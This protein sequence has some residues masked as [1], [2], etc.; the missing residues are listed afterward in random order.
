MA[1]S[2]AFIAIGLVLSILAALAAFLITYEEWSHHYTSKREPLKFA[3]E[4]SI[5]AFVVFMVLTILASAFVSRL[6]QS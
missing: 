2:N 4:A 5:V 1:Q 3:I 6:T